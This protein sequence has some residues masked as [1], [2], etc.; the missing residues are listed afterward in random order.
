MVVLPRVRRRKCILADFK[1]S[2]FPVFV[3]SICI[4][5]SY[6]CDKFYIALYGAL[7]EGEKSKINNSRKTRL[8]IILPE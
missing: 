5:I 6:I 3:F 4:C 8:N 1:I 2:Y 7:I